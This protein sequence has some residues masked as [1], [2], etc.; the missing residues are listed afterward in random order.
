MADIYDALT[1]ARP[2]KEGMAAEEALQIMHRETERGWRDPELM[3]AFTRL[4]RD[5]AST[6]TWREARG[7]QDSLRNL[8]SHLLEA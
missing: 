7:M 3:D 4:H 6:E 8:Q 2:Y 5:A 1:N